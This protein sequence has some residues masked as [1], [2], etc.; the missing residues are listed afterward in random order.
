VNQRLRNTLLG[1][2]NAVRNLVRQKNLTWRTAA[3]LDLGERSMSTAI[4][5]AEV[6]RFHTFEGLDPAEAAVLAALLEPMRL[7]AGQAVFRQGDPGDAVF[8]LVT[9]QV[10]VKIAGP[11]GVERV[12]GSPLEPG[13]VV[14]VIG[15]LLDVPRTA[16]I[17][18]RTA[19]ELWRLPR[20]AC[21]TSLER[22]ESWATKLL[23]ETARVLARRLSAAD[24]EIGSLIADLQQG[25]A[26]SAGR[27][28]ELERLRG[29]L[30][31][32]WS[33]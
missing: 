28:A 19:V 25:Q 17:T 3:K 13:T 5:P 30:F 15:P 10:E 24:R 4:D 18:A 31:N 20:T 14:G 29:R 32:E 2:Y 7:P 27:V 23:L 16:T 33:F 21:Q 6:R 9:G 12:V 1:G 26:K 22:R 8:L 11:D